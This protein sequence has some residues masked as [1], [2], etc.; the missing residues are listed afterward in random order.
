LST[1]NSDKKAGN[2]PHCTITTMSESP[3]KAGVLW[4]GTDDG[5][6][7]LTENDGK[8]WTKFDIPGAPKDYWVSRVYASPHETGTAFVSF[9][10]FREE[11][12]KP[13]LFKTTDFGKTW[14]SA[15]GN[16][17]D[18]QI[19]VVWQDTRNENLIF[20][21][22]EV[23]LHV[24]IDGGKTYSRFMNGLPMATPVQDLLVHERESDLII[25]THGRGIYIADIAPL[26]QLTPRILDQSAHL[27]DPDTVLSGA[28][29]G[30]MFDAFKGFGNW[31]AL[32]P[33]PAQIAYY[34]KESTTEPVT[35]EILGAGGNV[36]QKID[37]KKSAGIHYVTWNMR[38]AGDGT[39][40]VR[41]SVGNET[42]TRT[43]TVSNW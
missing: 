12:F 8:D 33:P 15:A 3:R 30:S 43:L 28:Q 35:V 20:V 25:G 37:G 23:G 4:V 10:G 32:N 31:V 5:N 19:A 40:G 26:R 16:L 36:L 9:T 18:Q 24:S 21:G 17:P 13:Y 2:V 22:T 38:Q 7:W 39:Y 41:L 27:F 14:A 6:V 34:L 11:D 42:L 1:D 29:A